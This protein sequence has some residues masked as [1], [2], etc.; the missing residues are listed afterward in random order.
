MLA[1]RGA[2]VGFRARYA[3]QT[4]QSYLSETLTYFPNVISKAQAEMLVHDCNAKLSMKKYEGNHFDSVIVD[5]REAE[6]S[7]GW[8]SQSQEIVDRLFSLAFENSALPQDTPRLPAHVIDLKAET[9][10]ILP[11]VDSTEFGGG[12]VAAL[13]LLS[14]R[15]LRLTEPPPEYITPTSNPSLKSGLIELD[16]PPCS[17]YILRGTARY[18]Y[19]HA[20]SSGPDRRLSIVFRDQPEPPEWAKEFL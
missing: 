8:S 2:K 6:M 3:T 4:R 14:S 15:R 19:A 7:M 10:E 9:G 1:S 13:S 5:Y 18:D 12:I 11:H 20:I 17:F 16:L